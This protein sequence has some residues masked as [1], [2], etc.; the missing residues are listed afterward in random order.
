[1]TGGALATTPTA[2]ASGP[3]PA[4]YTAAEAVRAAGVS[5]TTVNRWCREHV[6]DAVLVDGVWLLDG[7]STRAAGRAWADERE[8]RRSGPVPTP[9][10][11]E[12][13]AEPL[14]RLVALQGGEDALGVARG[15]AERR[16][17]ERARSRGVLTW[18]TADRLAVTVLGMTPWE[19]WGTA[20][21][22]A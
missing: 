13:L 4:T 19:V 22:A 14:L 2:G 7:P 10:H 18:W 3:G 8:R 1:M 11:D 15:S 21:S 5:R 9:G 12:L 20:W 6:V 17:L 16:A